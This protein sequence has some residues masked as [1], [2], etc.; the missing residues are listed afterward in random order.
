MTTQNEHVCVTSA[1]LS[2]AYRWSLYNNYLALADNAQ[3]RKEFIACLKEANKHN[4]FIN[5]N[6]AC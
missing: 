3:G 2:Y 5:Q 4:P 6:Y 1:C